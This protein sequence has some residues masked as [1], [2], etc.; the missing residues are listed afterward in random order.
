MS[1]TAIIFGSVPQ[2]DWGFA[3]AYF[4]VDPL[5]ICAD[6]GIRSAQASGLPPHILVGDGDSG[7]VAPA[8]VRFVPLKPEKD[9]SDAHAAV[10][11]AL[12]EGARRLILLGC[13]GGRADHYLANL[14]LLE[15]IAGHGASGL[16]VD[17]QNEI[18][19]FGGGRITVKN[20]P[21]YRYFG[22]L[23]IDEEL[24]GVTLS[25]VKYPLSGAS[26][27]R[28]DTLSISNEPLS[29]E[30]TVEVASGR[31]FLIRSGRICPRLVRKF[32]HV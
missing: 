2:R 1:Q 32:R 25:G 26:V 10:R 8:G 5:V 24:T 19:F 29:R 31:S 22:L 13:S 3:R 12:E 14:F 15:S 18:S 21:P 7:G 9:F 11:L 4:P 27:R 30:F 16:L 20:D 6:G 17:P 28:G 23:P